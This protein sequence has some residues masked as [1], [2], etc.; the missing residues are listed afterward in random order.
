MGFPTEKPRVSVIIPVYN[1]P[2]YIGQAVESVLNQ[3]NNPTLSCIRCL[4]KW[5]PS[6]YRM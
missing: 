3:T 4:E 1:C 2:D 6:S 5:S